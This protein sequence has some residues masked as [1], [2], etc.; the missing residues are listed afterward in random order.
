MRDLG[1][2]DGCWWTL[3]DRHL[4]GGWGVGVL[5]LTMKTYLLFVFWF[6]VPS[7]C[8]KYLPQ[9]HES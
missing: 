5:R 1:G 9:V 4:R 7:S 3:S 6:L 8:L 2:W